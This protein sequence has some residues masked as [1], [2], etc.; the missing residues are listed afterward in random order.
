M[1]GLARAYSTRVDVLPHPAKQEASTTLPIPKDIST[2]ARC[3]L[4]NGLLG[5]CFLKDEKKPRSLEFG[6]RYDCAEM[7]DSFVRQFRWF[8]NK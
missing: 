3:S 8:S 1:L 5:T 4:V 2:S 7:H 6:M